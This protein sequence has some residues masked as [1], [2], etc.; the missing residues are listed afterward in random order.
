MSLHTWGCTVKNSFIMNNTKNVPTYVGVYR[1]KLSQNCVG[2][3]CP[4]IRGGVPVSKGSCLTRLSMSLHTWGCTGYKSK[5][6]REINNVPTYV[7]VYRIGRIVLNFDNKCP[8]IRGGVPTA[9]IRRFI[10]K[11][12]SLHTWGCTVVIGNYL[13][14]HQN[15]PTY[16]GVYRLLRNSAEHIIE[17]PYIRGGV[18]MVSG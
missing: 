11:L 16:V 15:V 13:C 14:C 4:Y 8:Y 6:S 12:M 9:Y 2:F 5:Y 3:K 18:P 7:G 17:C 10:N 1:V